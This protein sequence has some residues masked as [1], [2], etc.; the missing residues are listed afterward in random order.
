MYNYQS[1]VAA[2]GLAAALLFGCD[3]QG[4]QD[5][6]ARDASAPPAGF[7]RTP[8]GSEIV[9]EDLDDW[10][11]APVYAGK[12]SIRPAYPNPAAVNDFVT[13]PFSV[14]TFEEVIA[15]VQLKT[16]R[17]SDRLL[18][19]L[20]TIDRASDP[21][22]YAF[23]FSAARVGSSGLHRLFIFDGAGELVSYGDLMIE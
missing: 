12:I 2:V 23:T 6:F 10:R 9:S 13:V 4:E 18:I 14:T 7:V 11:T 19:T 15:P 8:D 21:G 17:E 3:T 20:E 5:D 22:S 1:L 16:I